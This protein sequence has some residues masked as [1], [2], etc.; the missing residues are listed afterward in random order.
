M[1]KRP[2]WIIAGAFIMSA[3]GLAY[4]YL[5]QADPPAYFDFANQAMWLGIPNAA[6]V[7]SNV[8]FVIAG[9]LGLKWL[10][11]SHMD[12]GM[13]RLLALGLSVSAM[14]IGAGSAYFHWAPS[15]ATLFWDRLPM[16][17]FFSMF[18][19]LVVTDRIGPRF[20]LGTAYVLIP[21]GVMTVVGW[22]LNICDL[23][24]YIILQFGG[25][26][27]IF[28]I[29]ALT[30]PGRIRPAV[31]TAGFTLY[32]AAKLAEAADHTVFEF[33]YQWLSG[34]TLKHILAGAAMLALLKFIDDAARPA[35][36]AVRNS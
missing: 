32:L 17:L 5:P 10:L 33:T 35:V 29:L 13:Y 31:Y 20:G 6:D 11:Q 3:V 15:E 4:G 14:A 26:L 16:A 27:S 34:H 24:P 19:A 8:P 36:G 28:L 2:V 1:N 7:L 22:G 30:R 21:L 12:V 23:R 9:V 18:I 25:L